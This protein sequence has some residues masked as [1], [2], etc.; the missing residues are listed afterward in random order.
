MIIFER[1]GDD[2]V[3]DLQLSFI[4]VALGDEVEV[5][6]LTGKATITIAPGTQSGKILRMKS[7]GI[8]RLNSFGSGDQLIR[9]SVWTPTK[10]GPKEKEL[11]KGLAAFENMYPKKK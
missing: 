3:Y 10:L 11:L 5:P 6:T 9:I 2:V 1:H 8:P 7:K 4:Q